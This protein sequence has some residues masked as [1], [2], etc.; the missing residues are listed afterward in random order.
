MGRKYY[1][2][3]H[4]KRSGGLLKTVALALFTAWLGTRSGHGGHYAYR[5]Y[6]RRSFKQ[7]ALSYLVKRLTRRFT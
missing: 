2:P 1:H 7:S 4:R 5:P 6:R 3:K